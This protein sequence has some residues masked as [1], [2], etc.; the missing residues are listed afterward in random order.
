MDMKKMVKDVQDQAFRLRNAE[1]TGMLVRDE[2]ERMKNVLF[3]YKDE[4]LE[5]LAMADEAD[6]KI[7]VLELQLDDSDK[8]LAELE[9]ELKELKAAPNGKNVAGK[10]DKTPAVDEAVKPDVK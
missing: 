1:S 6:E 9:K 2:R 4:I 7:K 3:N 8:E 5:A 10:R